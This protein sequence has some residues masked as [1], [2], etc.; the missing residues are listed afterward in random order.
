MKNQKNLLSFYLEPS[1]HDTITGDTDGGRRQEWIG[2]KDILE[3]NN[4]IFLEKSIFSAS[5]ERD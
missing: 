1:R 4:L 5:G 3:V 2:G